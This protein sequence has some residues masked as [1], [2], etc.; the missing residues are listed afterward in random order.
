MKIED[1]IR[2]FGHY[3]LCQAKGG[4][5]SITIQ[6]IDANT[7]CVVAH[8]NTIQLPIEECKLVLKKLCN[9]TKIEAFRCAELADL[10]SALYVN[11]E[12]QI[13]SYGKTVLSFPGDNENYRNMV[14]FT[15]DNLNWRQIDYLR[16]Q[17][18]AI[19]LPKEI[20][21]EEMEEVK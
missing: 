8:D 19:G 4:N 17:G 15:E 6:S 3:I 7:G 21:E 18:Y 2:I 20:W 10:P 5:T 12:V 9:I 16:S 14:I 13:N 11:W 1:K